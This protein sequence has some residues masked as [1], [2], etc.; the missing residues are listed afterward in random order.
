MGR[1]LI[2][3]KLFNHPKFCYSL[4]IYNYKA[5]RDKYYEKLIEK[6]GL[7]N[8]AVKSNASVDKI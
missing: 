7:K 5:K 3:I 1:E 4:M 8:V 2:I 6:M